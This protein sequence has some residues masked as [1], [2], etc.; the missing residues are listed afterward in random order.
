MLLCALVAVETAIAIIDVLIIPTLHHPQSRLVK[1]RPRGL[2]LAKPVLVVVFLPHIVVEGIPVVAG[3]NGSH[4]G[5]I[6]EYSAI[7]YYV[8]L[9]L[10]CS[11]VSL[12][13]IARIE[14]KCPRFGLFSNNE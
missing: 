7:L 8:V 10:R 2:P 1:G 4:G 12:C 11:R 3:A 5:W 13:G 9:C 6:V 14:L